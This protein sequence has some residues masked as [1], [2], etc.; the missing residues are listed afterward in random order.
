MNQFQ[1]ASEVRD[2]HG[3]IPSGRGVLFGGEWVQPLN[4]GY[5]IAS[6]EGVYAEPWFYIGQNKYVS[7]THYRKENVSSLRSHKDS[8]IN[9]W[10]ANPY[11]PDT[12]SFFARL[13]FVSINRFKLNFVYRLVCK[14]ENEAAFFDKTKEISSNV[15]YPYSQREKIKHYEWARWKTPSGWPIYFNTLK[16]DFS[17]NIIQNLSLHGEFA[18]T[19]ASGKIKGNAINSSISVEYSIK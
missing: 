8:T 19:I 9:I 2:G 7:F 16:F 1:T 4:R 18:W 15:Y 12:I 10:L 17:Y 3:Y 5:L 11:G 6:L 13:G 14:G